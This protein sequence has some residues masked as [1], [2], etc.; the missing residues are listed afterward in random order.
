MLF[1]RRSLLRGALLTA[2]AGVAGYLVAANS[3]EARTKSGT[4]SADA[5]GPNSSRRGRLLAEVSQIPLGGG[6]VLAAAK[7]VLSRS[8]TGDVLAFSAIC[9]HQGCTVGSVHNGQVVCPCHGS[10][11]NAQSGAVITGPAGLPLPPVPVVV[12]NGG[13]YTA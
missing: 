2:V 5:Y 8:Q 11:F 12:H 10:R 7:I 4:T 1:S 9:T 6:I 3:S 13:V